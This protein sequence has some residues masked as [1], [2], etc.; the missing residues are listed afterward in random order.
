MRPSCMGDDMLSNLKDEHIQTLLRVGKRNK[1][2]RPFFG[3]AKGMIALREEASRRGIY[4]TPDEAQRVMNA[5][6]AKIEDS[7]K[8]WTRS[9]RIVQS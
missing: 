2:L 5:V 9:D 3:S 4:R 8:K 6:I 7:E 1:A